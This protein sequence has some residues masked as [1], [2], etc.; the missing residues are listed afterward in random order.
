MRHPLHASA[1]RLFAALAFLTGLVGPEDAAAQA[2]DYSRAERF[3]TWNTE[4]LIARAEVVP[5]W[6]ETGD[7]DRF[8]YRN[9][10]GSGYEFVLV[11][12][13]ARHSSTTTVWLARCR[14]PTTPATSPTSCLSAR[15]A[16]PATSAAS[17]SW[18]TAVTSAATS[19]A[20]TARWR[21]PCPRGLPYVKSPDGRWEAFSHEYNLYMCAVARQDERNVEHMHYISYTSQRPRHF[22]QPYALPGDSVIPLPTVHVVALEEGDVAAGGREGVDGDGMMDGSGSAP[23]LRVVA[24]HRVEVAPIPHQLSF[25]G[26]GPDSAWSADGTRLHVNYFT[27]GSQ[28]VFL[29]EIDAATGASRVILG[30]STRTFV[31]LGHRGGGSSGGTPSWYVSQSGEDVIWWSERDGWAHLYRFDGQGNLKN[32]IT[33]GPW[34][35]AQALLVDETRQRIYFTARG[36]EPGRNP[37]Y[38][39]LYRVGFDGS[40]LTLLTPEDANHVIEILAQQQLLRGLLLT[41]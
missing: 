14:S 40:G 28:R 17:S 26:S 7:T 11:N 27:R 37:Y 23:A 24:N 9:T 5:N 2:V 34:T 31:S 10:T 1:A 29:A 35:V 6:L 38:A 25:A 13:A 41:C 21:T 19:R 32:Q 22:S 18:R 30:D 12:P 8:W 4:R 16:S 39:H 36:C 33:S 15:S 20:T 3:L